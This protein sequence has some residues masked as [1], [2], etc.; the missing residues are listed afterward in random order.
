VTVAICDPRVLLRIHLHDRRIAAEIAAKSLREAQ[1]AI[2]EA[3]AD[4]IALTLQVRLPT[5]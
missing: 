5:T 3:G 4:D 1:G 2:R